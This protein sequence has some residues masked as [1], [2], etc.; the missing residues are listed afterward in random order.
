VI[1][2]G[3]LYNMHTLGDDKLL[4]IF[5]IPVDSDGIYWQ[6]FLIT[7]GQIKQIN[8]IREYIEV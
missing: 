1:L 5:Q 2:I 6:V 8:S 3:A 4:Q 7:N